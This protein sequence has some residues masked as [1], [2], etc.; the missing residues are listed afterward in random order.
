MALYSRLPLLLLWPDKEVSEHFAPYLILAL[1]WRED[2]CRPPYT[3]S[4]VATGGRLF[5]MPTFHCYCSASSAYRMS[6]GR[7]HRLRRGTIQCTGPLIRNMF[8]RK[9]S[10][11]RI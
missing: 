10:S 7:F 8:V 4:Q 6:V 2:V 1:P 5:Q 11:L 9:K 3:V